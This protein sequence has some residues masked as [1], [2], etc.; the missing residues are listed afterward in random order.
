ME[1]QNPDFS[2][3]ALQA[4]LFVTLAVAAQANATQEGGRDELNE[5]SIT[6]PFIMH[7]AAKMAAEIAVEHTAPRS[8]DR[9]IWTQDREL[10]SML[11]S[12]G[13]DPN[14]ISSGNKK[15]FIIIAAMQGDPHII[16]LLLS[17]GANINVDGDSGDALYWAARQGNLQATQF[18]IKH[19]A[20]VTAIAADG[21][22][23]LHMTLGHDNDVRVAEALLDAGADIEARQGEM[24][25]LMQAALFGRTEWV[26]LFI[27][28]GANINATTSSMATAF[29]ISSTFGRNQEIEDMLLKA[30]ADQTSR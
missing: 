4:L 20:D 26:E 3:Y 18:L 16:R 11:L 25:P 9:A 27:K 5:A 23:A 21:S 7:P 8:L 28:H 2:R 17:H 1:R 29:S 14:G 12:A 13:A 22:T 19:G 10:T 24:T 30:G 15:P 6:G